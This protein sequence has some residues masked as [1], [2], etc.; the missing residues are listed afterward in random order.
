MSQR[1]ILQSVVSVPGERTQAAKESRS[2]SFLSEEQFKSALS[3]E[4]MRC[5][6]CGSLIMLALMYFE[7]VPLDQL[8]GRTTS[9]SHM[10]CSVVRETDSAGWYAHG[11]VIGVI[12]T[13]LEE[14][15]KVDSMRVIDA[16]LN[17]VIK[18][19]LPDHQLS[20]TRISY[21]FFPEAGDS[22]TD[23]SSVFYPEAETAHAAPIQCI[24]KR[25]MD[26]AGS[27]SALMVLWPVMLAIAGI[28]KWTSEGPVFFRQERIGKFG[29]RFTFLK[30]RSMY[31]NNDHAIH[32]EYVAQL[33]AGKVENDGNGSSTVYKITSDPRVTPIGKF[34]RRTSMD[35]LPQFINVLKGEMSLVGPRPPVPYEF[36]S[37]GVWHRRRVME[38]KPG[39]TGLWQVNG[40]SRT[41]FD[42]MVRLD[43]RYVRKWSLWL[44]LKILLQTPLVVLTGDGA[45]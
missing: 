1:A 32:R 25:T 12:F 14:V 15:T 6:R 8:Q 40:R 42:E 22:S 45:Y 31:H 44:D 16:R 9:V 43:L 24:L 3:R 35:E 27:L 20:R 11:S 7:Q 21:Y 19:A 4:R 34:L 41:T 18:T 30:Y 28:I 38:V 33:I 17:E 29:R 36:E 39:I 5:E 37:Y 2:T 10:L 23:A 26:L 13:C